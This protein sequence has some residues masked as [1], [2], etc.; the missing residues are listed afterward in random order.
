MK[1]KCEDCKFWMEC[2]DYGYKGYCR[3]FPPQIVPGVK[4]D[5]EKGDDQYLFSSPIVDDNDWCGEFKAR[6]K[7]G[8][9]PITTNS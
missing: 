6:F 8:L 7:R 2:C 3:R 4:N 5:P 9:P 1:D